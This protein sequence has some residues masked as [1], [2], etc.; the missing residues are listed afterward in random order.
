[1]KRR[2]AGIARYVPG[3]ALLGL[4]VWGTGPLRRLLG[5]AIDITLLMILTMVGT[6]WYLGRG[7][8][9]VVAILFEAM[10][11]YFAGVP[12]NWPRALIIGFNRLL[13]FCGIV[14][15][16]SARRAAEDRLRAQQ[17]TLEATLA[18]ERMAREDAE[19]ANRFKDEFLATISHELRTPLNALLGWAQILRKQNLDAPISRKAVDAIERGALAQARIVEDVL[20]MS[21]MTAGV[22]SMKQEPLSFSSVVDEAVESMRPA[23]SDKEIALSVDVAPH[24]FVIGDAGRIRQIAWNLISNAIKFTPAG[25]SLDVVLERVEGSV[26]LSVRDTGIGIAPDFLPCVF[27]RFRQADASMTREQ[28]GLGIGLAI[29]HELASQHGG[30]V[31]A[32]SDGLGKGATDPHSRAAFSCQVLSLITVARSTPTTRRHRG[33]QPLRQYLRAP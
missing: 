1:M 8:G 21:R 32:E 6:A 11:D 13:L 30:S 29:V 26:Q 22:L 23:A 17:E 19:K 4:L 10:L 5:F 2:L 20:D 12:T 7:P 18:R 27:D 14:W 31:R 33:T 16:A 15:F 9:L 24:L 25:G 28:G 3:T